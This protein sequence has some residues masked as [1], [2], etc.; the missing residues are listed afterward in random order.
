VA[1]VI[2]AAEITDMDDLQDVFVRASLSNEHDREL[3]LEHPEWLLL[4]SAGVSEGRMLAAVDGD[5]GAVGFVTYLVVD[6]VAE[7]DDLFVDPQWMRRGIG[8]ALVVEMAARV[9]GL[10]FDTLEVTANPHAM[11][12]Y[13]RLGFV[14]DRVVA[15]LGYPAHRLS[16]PSGPVG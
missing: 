11:A 7:L 4:S 5:G 12:F 2:R 15:T 16:R 6:G 1:I 14:E 10:G 3:L 9:H 13:A 8:A